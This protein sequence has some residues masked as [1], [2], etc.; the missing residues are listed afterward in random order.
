MP[1]HRLALGYGHDGVEVVVRIIGLPRDL[2]ARDQ[3]TVDLDPDVPVGTDL[4]A[5]A[6]PSSV[7]RALP[8]ARDPHRRS[9]VRHEGAEDG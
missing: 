1:G 2:V 6:E 4:V 5:D 8:A 3:G 7:I 9:V